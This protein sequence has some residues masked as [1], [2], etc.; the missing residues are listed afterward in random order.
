MS[1]KNVSRRGFIKGAAGIAAA[2]GLAVSTSA[3]ESASAKSVRLGAPVFESADDPEKLAVAHKT[4]GYRAAYCPNVK[5]EDADRIKAISDAFAK[6]DVIIAEVGRWC[7]MLDADPGKRKHNIENVTD[8]LALAEAIG[9]R[10]CVDIA[11]S[12]NPESWFGPHP[13]NLSQEFFDAAVENARAI[14]DAVKPKRAKFAYEMMGWSLPDSAD[15][16]VKLIKAVDREGF[17]VHLDPCNVINCPERF[18]RNADVLNECFDKLGPHIV[19]C[20]AKDLTWDIEMNVHFREVR[21]G[22]GSMDYTVYLKRLVE[23]P[24]QPPLMVEHLSSA[25]EYD[26]ARKYLLELGPKIGVSF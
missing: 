9:A 2:T 15:S 7:N 26:E 6:Q 18:Y 25:E 24:Q 19:S 17:G 8:G 1:K 22:A 20:H 4:L 5:L 14:I 16:Y 13:K 11:G 10:C 12:F 23:L 21:P 3:Q